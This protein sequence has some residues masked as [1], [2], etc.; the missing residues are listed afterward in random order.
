MDAQPVLSAD[1]G[2]DTGNRGKTDCE[3]ERSENRYSSEHLPRAIGIQPKSG[4]L[5]EQN[6][7]I[8]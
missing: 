1:P 4:K 7:D 8:P 6:W 2:A 5:F 3:D